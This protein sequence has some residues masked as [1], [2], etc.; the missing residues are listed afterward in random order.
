MHP[1]FPCLI[2]HYTT[3]IF[4]GHLLNKLCALKSLSP[5]LLLGVA[6]RHDVEVGAEEASQ[7]EGERKRLDP[8]EKT[9]TKR[10]P[11]FLRL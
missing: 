6:C 4:G 9:T 2:F 3:S 5:G 10:S 1:S 7:R 8:K 11:V